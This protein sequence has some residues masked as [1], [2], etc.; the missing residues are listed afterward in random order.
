MDSPQRLGAPVPDFSLPALAGGERSLSAALEGRRGAVV[1]FW[2]GV[3]SHC[4]RYDAYLGRWPHDELAL[5]VVASR[6]GEDRRQLEAT[7]ERRDLALP[8]LL[9]EE[10]RVAHRFQVAQTPRAFLVD[11]ARRLLYRGAIDNYRYPGEAGYEAYLEEAIADF[12]A[13]RPLRRAE[14]ASY[15]CPIESVYYSLSGPGRR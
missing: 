2:S 4:V 3:C 5:L 8:L 11:G 9:D 6:Q 1:V 14:T 13:G 15:G 12:L 7:V 10:R